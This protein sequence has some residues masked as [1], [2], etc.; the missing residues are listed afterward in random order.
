MSDILITDEQAKALQEIA[1]TT[2]TALDLV[3][4][5]GSYVKWM[6]GTVPADLIGVLG[7]NWLSQVRIRNLAWYKRRTEQIIREG[8]AP[9]TEAVS[10]SLAIPLLR[11]AMDENRPQLQELW[12]ALLAAAADPQRSVLVRQSFI[13]TI[14]KFDPLDASVLWG[15]YQITGELQP[16]CR[17]FLSRRLEVS[18]ESIVVSIM[19]LNKLECISLNG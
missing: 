14:S 1:K 8:G 9:Q 10:P 16:T 15:R 2:G 17:E 5:A 12:A 4:E 11:A 7:G 18:S 3:G 13:Y 19:N 6:L